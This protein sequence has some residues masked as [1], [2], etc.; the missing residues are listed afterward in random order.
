MRVSLL[1]LLV[2]F[3]S[4]RTAFSGV[5]IR[6]SL[7]HI[8]YSL[9]VDVAP[10]DGTRTTGKLKL[11]EYRIAFTACVLTLLSIPNVAR[12]IADPTVASIGGSFLLPMLMSS[13]WFVGNRVQSQVV[14]EGEAGAE[15]PLM[16]SWFD[17]LKFCR[18]LRKGFFHRKYG[19]DGGGSFAPLR[20]E[21]HLGAADPLTGDRHFKTGFVHFKDENGVVRKLNV[22]HTR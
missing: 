9:G 2:V 4:S 13:F 8:E 3:L 21:L 12:A 16:I 14:L 17:A 10:E 6:R 7:S 20:L 22:R 18:F 5:E 11:R 15:L 1:L 19:D